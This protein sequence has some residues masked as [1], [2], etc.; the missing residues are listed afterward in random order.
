MSYGLLT[1]FRNHSE[2]NHYWYETPSARMVRSPSEPR[3]D[4][5]G[6][7]ED[8]NKNTP[9]Y[10]NTLHLDEQP[11]IAEHEVQGVVVLPATAFISMAIEAAVRSAAD[12]K[13]AERVELRD[14]MIQRPLLFQDRTKGID[15]RVALKPHRA[16]TR[17][18][19]TTWTHVTISSRS[20]MDDSWNEHA[21]CYFTLHYK[22]TTSDVEGIS[23]RLR[24]AKA[25]QETYLELKERCRIKNSASTIYL[26]LEDCGFNYG[27]LFKN[28]EDLYCGP[29][30]AIGIVSI[31]D[32]R[33][34]MPKSHES[35][36]VVHPIVLDNA[37][38]LINP[39][40]RDC[41]LKSTTMLPTAMES[42]TIDLDVPNSPNAK[43]RGYSSYQL[44]GYHDMLCQ[45]VLGAGDFEKPLITIKNLS[46]QEVAGI[47]D[48]DTSDTTQAKPISTELVWKEDIDLLSRTALEQLLRASVRDGNAMPKV[49]KYILALADLMSFKNPSLTVFEMESM[50][51][52]LMERTVARLT[53]P[54]QGTRMDSYIMSGRA[55]VK[56]DWATQGI[57]QNSDIADYITLK[58]G[59][60]AEL[61]KHNLVI[62]LH[63]T[64]ESDSAHATLQRTRAS[65]HTYGKFAFAMKLP[66]QDPKGTLMDVE[67]MLQL[68]G[69]SGI[70]AA[71]E[72]DEDSSL[73]VIT[74]KLPVSASPS[75]VESKDIM[76]VEPPHESVDERTWS[77]INTFEDKLIAAGHKVS[78]ATIQSLRDSEDKCIVSFLGLGEMT[79]N[80]VCSTT[81]SALRAMLLRNA[82][83]MWVSVDAVEPRRNPF[84]AMETGLLRVIRSEEPALR[85]VQFDY[86]SEMDIGSNPA[87]ELLMT[88]VK[89]SLLA[90]Q[91]KV[92]Q[93]AHEV[94]IRER[95]GRLF[96]PRLFAE[97]KANEAIY[98]HTHHPA[99]QR[100]RIGNFKQV[101]RLRTGVPGM[102]D[103][104]R[105]AEVDQKKVPM[106]STA[107][108]PGHAKVRVQATPINFVDVMVAMGM[109]PSA[110]LGCECAG[111]VVEASQGT[112]R[113]FHF[114]P[115]PRV[116]STDTILIG[117]KY[118]IGDQ[119]VVMTGNAFAT[120]VIDEESEY[121]L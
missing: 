119:V 93:H 45:I 63:H 48:I 77:L 8:D 42:I 107:L 51:S 73:F 92:D 61:A 41:G 38:Q 88:A 69:F 72:G 12:G 64:I 1:L 25:C 6:I 87:V 54:G 76:L 83:L 52:Q 91:E 7:L 19:S 113:S 3:H 21:S 10:R 67:V 118:N 115:S 104:L 94:E 100:Q 121:L 31:P 117:G 16:G 120:H 71:V 23:E 34:A 74:T 105:F 90:P 103:T 15:T 82:G 36:H 26:T 79:L 68:A 9:Q 49:H 14:V 40:L 50:G 101:L 4:L 57:K 35:P 78:H 84:R 53:E 96:I 62:S 20:N 108:P 18:S 39:A 86:S 46:V 2:K 47:M 29:P 85:L 70:D 114:S 66:P 109:V 98:Y 60:D 5:L 22:T 81:Y 106:F 59:E 55:S 44:R 56:P 111:V 30:Y 110:S 11:W 24:E 13:I 37:I 27:P 32:T 28:L 99:A 75:A 80:Q 58:D 33:A 112:Y 97:Q 95:D 17:L 65:L 89:A 116:A 102:L 43:L